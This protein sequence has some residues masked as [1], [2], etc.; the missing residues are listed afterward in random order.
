MARD[1]YIEDTAGSMARAYRPDNPDKSV[2]L[3]PFPLSTR[4][5]HTEASFEHT[6]AGDEYAPGMKGIRKAEQP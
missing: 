5:C 4:I 3:P 6:R 2:L 1:P